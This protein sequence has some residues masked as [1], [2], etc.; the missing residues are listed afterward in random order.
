M[1]INI[2]SLNING[3]NIP[4]KRKKIFN[5][6]QK[7]KMDIIYLQET[8]IK[9][10]DYKLFENTKLFPPSD[11][12]KKKC[13]IAMYVRPTLKSNFIKADTE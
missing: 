3:L 2:L 11:K 9:N 5:K 6:L 8:H 12:N 4:E 1:K 13:R 10:K 7:E